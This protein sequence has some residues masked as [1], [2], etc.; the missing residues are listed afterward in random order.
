MNN[1]CAIAGTWVI[2]SLFK[3]TE[4]TIQQRQ[5]SVEG[6]GH[7]HRCIGFCSIHYQK[8][9]RYG[10]ALYIHPKFTVRPCKI[11]GCTGHSQSLGMCTKHYQ[12]YCI[13]GD[14]CREPP[15]RIGEL[16]SNWK[17][18]KV[19]YK[20][21]H[22]WISKH[23][24]R[25]MKCEIC[26]TEDAKRFDWANVSG[27]YKRAR[28]DWKRLCK[29]CHVQMDGVWR[30]K[31]TYKSSQYKGVTREGKRWVAR[32]TVN[33]HQFNLG[34]FKTEVDAAKEY[35]KK[36]RELCNGNAFLNFPNA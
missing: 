33:R 8:Y 2:L 29:K 9:R 35:D 7:K 3:M 18:D 12:R 1:P 19:G 25:P 15:K 6:C 10:D 30:G 22:C 34:T 17:G 13:H 14:P 27:K 36:V 11:D 21:L 26:K 28:S 16:A 20:G 32:L 31:P 23:F 5:C 4:K 24:G